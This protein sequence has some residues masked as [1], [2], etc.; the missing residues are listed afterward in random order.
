MEFTVKSGEAQFKVR[1]LSVED[2]ILGQKQ[3]NGQKICHPSS[4]D[5][6]KYSGRKG[7]NAVQSYYSGE[8]FPGATEELRDAFSIQFKHDGSCGYV[9]YDEETNTLI[10]YARQEVKFDKK[11]G[12]FP[13]PDPS[14]IACSE[15]PIITD[16]SSTYHWPF[17][18]KCAKDDP[19]FKHHITAFNN[20]IQ[21]H[22]EVI[23]LKKSFTCEYMGKVFN[24]K[25]SDFCERLT[26]IVHGIYQIDIPSEYRTFDKLCSIL[27]DCPF[28]EGFVIYCPTTIYKIRRDLI[29]DSKNNR[30]YGWGTMKTIDIFESD[31]EKYYFLENGGLSS[32]C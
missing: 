31:P 17:F 10:P 22:P 29:W 32:I 30:C 12:K 5:Q 16:S 18:R 7:R 27:I 15:M 9:Q 13:D 28:T 24:G 3:F 20:F 8:L 6:M 2:A 19:Q 23:G 25:N 14:W 1:Q 26:L 11:T 4:F 21:Q